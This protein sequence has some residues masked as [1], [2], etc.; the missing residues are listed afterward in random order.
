MKRMFWMAALLA[1]PSAMT[2]SA[3]DIDALLGD[4]WYGLY[5]NGEKA[6]YALNSLSRDE[7][8]RVI[9]VEDA[10]FMVN[11][12]GA[13]QDLRIFSKR[14]YAAD[15]SLEAIVAQVTDPAGISDFNARIEGKE[16]VLVS[17]TGGSTDEQRLPAPNETLNDSIKHSLWVR[18]K[19][20]LGDAINFSTFEPMYQQEVAGISHIVGIEERILDGIPTTVYQIKTMLDLMGVESV[21]AV[22]ENGVTLE[23]VVSG[24]IVKRIEPEESAKD[25]SYSSDVI[26]SNAAL[27]PEPLES[28]RSMESLRLI[29]RGP[30]TTEHLFDDERQT[31][32][33]KEGYFLFTGRRLSPEG[34][35]GATLPVDDPELLRWTRPTVFVQSEEPRI[36]AQAK[37]IV[38]DE[39]DV[40]KASTKLCTWVNANMRSTFSARLTNALE[41]LTSLEGDCTEHSILFIA[42]ARAAGIP[43]RE[44]AGLVYVEGAKPGFYFHQWAKIWAG[45]WIDMDPTFNQPLVDV[46]HIKLAEG[47]LIK[48]AKLIPVIGNLKIE[49]APPEPAAAPVAE[50]ATEHDSDTMEDAAS[51]PE[52]AS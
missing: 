24:I 40:F 48:Q 51:V 42:L 19:P 21:A 27:I 46:T 8:G 41:V 47:D 22:A 17:V 50:E 20:Q 5:L 13:K 37:E 16:L 52:N 26:V 43:A 34:I 31:I 45:Q 39:Q 6:G 15:G 44:V 29:L 2:Q 11:M 14:V 35:A 7:S 28:P 9:A 10:R 49:V 30:L 18:Q 38:G 12:V 25:V 23:D 1:A 3:L 32:V 4:T 33:E 36:V